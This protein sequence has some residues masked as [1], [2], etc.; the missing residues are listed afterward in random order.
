MKS[1]ISFF[2]R[3]I[4]LN[5]LKRYGWIGMLYLIALFFMV[6]L[7]I[8]MKYE[9][10]K[11]YYNDVNTY[12]KI[13][14]LFLF[15]HTA[16]QAYS[17]LIIAVLLA[18]FLFRYMQSKKSCDMLHSLPVKRKT[19]YTTHIIAGSFLMIVPVVLTGFI[20][21]ALNIML[22][23][24]S[25]YT[26][27]DIMYW[28]GVTL[29]MG[30]FIF[31]LSVVVGML[32]G[33]SIIQ[34]IFTYVFLFLPIVT[35]WLVNFNLEIFIYGFTPKFGSAEN[36]KVLA[37]I[38]LLFD[39]RYEDN[40]I[41]LLS[42]IIYS[43]VT[44]ILYFLGKFLYDKRDLEAATQTVAFL[45]L[46]WLFK[47]LFVFYAMLIGGAYFQ[48]V[49]RN[50]PW[51]FF[52][53]IIGSFFGYIIAEMLLKK[54]VY[55]FKNIKAYF[56]Y[57]AVISLSLL[58]L[59]IGSSAYEKRIPALD[60]IENVYFSDSFYF[61]DS[62]T[63]RD[64]YKE[65]DT[66]QSIHLLHQ[67]LIK[68]KKK[69]KYKDTSNWRNELY[70][71]ITF[72]YRLKNKKEIKRGYTSIAY[73]EYKKYFKPI[74]E[75]MEDKTNKNPILY[76]TQKDIASIDIQ[77]RMGSNKHLLLT[78]LTEI[79]ELLEI[80]KT[81]IKNE[82]YEEMTD[83][84]GSWGGLQI[85]LKEESKIRDLI[86]YYD[87]INDKKEKSTRLYM[88]LGRNYRELE[89]WLKQKGYLEKAILTSKDVSYVV[90]E[91]MEN[92]NELDIKKKQMSAEENLIDKDVKQLEI[93]DKQE[94]EVCLRNR[95][96]AGA[97]NQRK[98]KVIIYHEGEKQISKAYFLRGYV[99]DFVENY[100]K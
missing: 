59:N 73:D 7:Q 90:V 67:Q 26:I 78:D 60:E 42:V 61:L 38:L 33:N 50:M 71:S 31:I 11:L 77:D 74:R 96:E 4:F 35:K 19:L 47:Y 72:E 95:T 65:K 88:E 69:N 94:I 91:E 9:E 14:N 81:E 5:D 41:K 23:L 54:S 25:L 36:F 76:A 28:A 3:G 10:Q 89:E 75:S 24:R 51:L 8:L 17:M 20:S 98:Y 43:A 55:V 56:A 40:K 64:V 57:V 48:Q 87:Y 86:P 52:G 2:N 70:R 30:L 62:G 44:I 12:N 79:Q 27:Q 45:Q 29:F 34:G 100:F 39:N 99:P 49:K 68:D 1:K 6:P 16:V 83:P 32:T 18:I 63:E 80:L 82:T 85:L 15:K 21:Y 84:R 22:D 13:E 46:R 66:I 58:F 92:L 93:R 37:P 97:L 53:Y